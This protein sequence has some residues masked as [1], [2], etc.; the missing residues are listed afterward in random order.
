MKG[1]DL[2]LKS[3]DNIIKGIPAAPGLVIANAY[4]YTKEQLRITKGS[5]TD[6]ETAVVN[7]HEALARSK[8]ELNKIFSLA[9]NKMGEKR[10][11]IFEAQLMI[12]D[13]PVLIETIEK[14]IR[15]EKLQPEFIVND[16]I[17]KY[18]EL[19][20][21]SNQSLMQER[22]H[23]ID[24]IKTR[25]I[26][27]LQ[28]KRLTGKMKSNVAVVS[29]LLSPADTLLFARNNV[30]G[31]VTDRGGL[32]SH[33]A[34]VA[35]SLDIP[36]VTGTHD[37]T[38]KIK[39]DD[40][41]IIDGF[42]GYVFVNPTEEQKAYFTGKIEH[43]NR[44]NAELAELKNEPAMTTDGREIKLMANVDVSG[45]I[46]Y[47]ISNGAKGI[48]LYRTEQIIEEF[49]IFPEEEQQV[50]IYSQLAHRIY[51]DVI[52]IRAFDLGGDKVR[53]FHDS[54]ANPFLGLRGIRFLLENMKLFR[55]QVRAILR[56]SESRNIQFMIPMVSTL[57]EIKKTR[58]L[59]EE[60]KAELREEGKDFD[61]NMKFGIMIEVPSAAVLAYD[62]GKEVDFISIG[63]NDLIQ[64]MMA[65]DRGNDLV[66]PLYQE[67]HP[68]VLRTLS[69]IVHEGKRA[70]ACVSICGEMAVDTLAVP[71]LVGIG[72]D[73]FSVSPSAIPSLKRTIRAMSY[74]K[75]KQLADECLFLITEK[76]ITEHIRKFF[77][78]NV[79]IRTR[80]IL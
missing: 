41:I 33:A 17:T 75:A 5:I 3:A 78:D 40:E 37:G 60:V 47:V 26:R 70:E 42:H 77:V 65:V 54:E 15:E 73:S 56:A 13:D 57:Q 67:F 74:E 76:E 44:I 79:I 12:L 55:T 53:L 45:E 46:A 68:S 39:Q 16:E 20:V 25:I 52:T 72:L 69:H 8:K 14:R 64:Y 22:A 9:K 23:D 80:D 28:K 62:Y 50:E 4:T 30:M 35:R 2:I 21:I 48:G 11:A 10:A 1:L 71:F 58:E 63:T 66:Y 32:T 34:I 6:T 24:D 38:E 31:Y 59:I 49:G 7:F 18:Q 19:M 61:E 36:A 51:P 43:M 27:N 29:D